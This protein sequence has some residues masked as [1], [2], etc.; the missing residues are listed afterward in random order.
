MSKFW[1]FHIFPKR[2]EAWQNSFEWIDIFNL[3][4]STCTLK[5]DQ[6]LAKPRLIFPG[7]IELKPCS[8]SRTRTFLVESWQA[9]VHGDPTRGTNEI[10]GVYRPTRG[11]GHVYTPVSLQLALQPG[12]IARYKSP[13]VKKAGRIIRRKEGRPQVR[14]SFEEMLG[15]ITSW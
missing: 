9:K 14:V 5:I 10:V 3:S 15:R 12:L 4:L 11:P 2:F 8:I 13:R 6:A 7:Q 1:N